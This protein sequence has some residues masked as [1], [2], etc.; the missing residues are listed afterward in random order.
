MSKKPT[1]VMF[2]GGGRRNALAKMFKDRGCNVFSYEIDNT[3]PIRTEAKIIE[4]DIF[5]SKNFIL[6]LTQSIKQHTIDLVIPLQDEAVP[7]CSGIKGA[8]C[9]PYH[10][11]MR[12]GDKLLFETF[13]L[14]NFAE[15]YPKAKQGEKLI[16]K[17]RFGFGARGIIVGASL[18]DLSDD[19]VFQSYKTGKEYTVDA[20]FDKNSK[21]IG[22]S[23]RER[24]RIA[25]GEVVD[26]V[27][28]NLPMLEQN[29]KV[30]GESLELIGPICMQFIV[31][32]EKPY[33]FEVN[34]RFGGGSTLS[35]YAGLDMIN[36]IKEEYVE[37]TKL[38]PSNYIAEHNIFL[39]RVFQ[40]TYCK[41]IE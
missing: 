21:M 35:I 11:A 39:K 13:M 20:Y 4:G 23:P 36:M 31:E 14:N 30:V 26:S 2:V 6:N 29:T 18:D 22:C 12:C 7:L 10:S 17:P 15:L 19:Y 41:G 28:V 34:A 32:N 3:A 27:T 37:N 38:N 24:L 33:L 9:S 5:A 16:K 8:V 40:D 25:D 1:N